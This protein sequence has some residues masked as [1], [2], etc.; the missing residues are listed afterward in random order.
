MPD[1]YALLEQRIREAE[2]DPAK[3]R[4]IVYEAARLALKRHVNVAPVTLQEG[5]ELSGELEAA[6]ERLEADEG[7]TAGYPSTP[8]LDKIAALL[9]PRPDD[10]PAA[11]AELDFRAALA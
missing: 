11:I 8:V 6:I 4:D 10:R 3:L 1:F 5:K 7:R 9:R 2:N